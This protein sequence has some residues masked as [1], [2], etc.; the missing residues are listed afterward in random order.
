MRT[1]KKVMGLT[2]GVLL[3]LLP[4]VHPGPGATE[5]WFTHILDAEGFVGRN[6]SLALD[7]S[8]RP[9]ISYFDSTHSALKYA[10]IGSG[11]FGSSG[12]WTGAEV[13]LRRWAVG[14]TAGGMES[15][16]TTELDADMVLDLYGARLTELSFD[17]E[18][19]LL[20]PFATRMMTGEEVS[21]YEI[22]TAYEQRVGRVVRL[23]EIRQMLQR[24][25]YWDV[26]GQVGRLKEETEKTDLIK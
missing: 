4:P 15:L 18:A 2:M 20:A 12:S 3:V 24:H 17:E 13:F 1:E 10:S 25:G 21:I 6:S 8:V 14:S 19:A 9:H 11:Y 16:E 23:M 26:E 7:S 5:F 22:E